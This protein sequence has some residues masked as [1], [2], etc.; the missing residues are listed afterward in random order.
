MLRVGLETKQLDAHAFRQDLARGLNHW[1]FFGSVAP[2]L[3]QPVDRSYSESV[4]EISARLARN[5]DHA[6]NLAPPKKRTRPVPRVRPSMLGQ[7]LRRLKTCCPKELTKK[8][9]QRPLQE[10]RVS[11]CPREWEHSVYSKAVPRIAGEQPHARAHSLWVS[12]REPR[13]RLSIAITPSAAGSFQSSPSTHIYN[14][15]SLVCPSPAFAN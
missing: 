11:C 8:V 5:L 13:N 7:S 10:S 6:K 4:R 3:H 2:C 15:A 9:Y 14:V 12:L 1:F